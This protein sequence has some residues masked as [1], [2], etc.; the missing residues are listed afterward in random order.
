MNDVNNY[1]VI[2][3]GGGASG[4]MAG[5]IC[6]GKGKSV[7]ILEKNKSLGAK[8]AISG[9]GRCNI[10]NDEDD[11]RTFLSIYSKK[12]NADQFL[13]SAFSQFN[14]NDTF[15]FFD[16]LGLPLV[17]EARK[18]AFPNTQKSSYFVLFLFWL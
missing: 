3:V 12:K 13:F 18:R 17:V 9:G 2:V 11:L 7:L 4:M 10:T 16:K 14:K 6:A 15:K 8:L 5:G 1:D